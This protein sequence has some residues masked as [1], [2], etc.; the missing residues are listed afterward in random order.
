[1]A[2]FDIVPRTEADRMFLDIMDKNKRGWPAAVEDNMVVMNEAQKDRRADIIVMSYLAEKYTDRKFLD[3][4]CGDGRVADKV[5][6]R[7]GISVGYD[8]TDEGWSARGPSR[9]K[10]TTSLDEVRSAGPYEIVLAFDVLDHTKEATEEITSQISSVMNP[11][12]RLYVRGHPWFSPH[13]GHCYKKINK[14][15]AHLFLSDEM[16]AD[17]TDA[18]CHNKVIESLYYYRHCMEQCGLVLTESVQHRKACPK[19]FSQP[20]AIKKFRE[21]L[22]RRNAH[23]TDQDILSLLEIEF[24]DMVFVKD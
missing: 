23:L 13:G 10:L 14:S 7:R 19:I 4:G 20:W 3:F 6:A 17:V 16:L 12:A 5:A 21:H 2:A 15:H 18:R 9:A 1:M 11:G 22:N 8:I 24:V